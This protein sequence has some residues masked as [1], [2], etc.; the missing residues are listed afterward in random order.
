MPAKSEGFCRKSLQSTRE[1]YHD[2]SHLRIRREKGLLEH[3]NNTRSVSLA[4]LSSLRARHHHAVPFMGGAVTDL[5][6]SGRQ[7][8]VGRHGEYLYM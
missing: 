2:G 1:A 4:I 6:V 3:L 7:G 5:L 8:V